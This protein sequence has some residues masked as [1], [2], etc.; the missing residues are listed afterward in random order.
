MVIAVPH[1]AVAMAIVRNARPP[2]YVDDSK[3]RVYP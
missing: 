2:E 1:P 3:T